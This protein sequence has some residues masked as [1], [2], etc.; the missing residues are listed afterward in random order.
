[1]TPL[2]KQVQKM[3]SLRKNNEIC[4]YHDYYIN[5]AGFGI[6]PVYRGVYHQRGHGLGSFLRGLWRMTFPLIKSGA[7]T[8]GD[9]IL[10]SGSEFLTDVVT[11]KPIKESLR[12]RLNETTKNL[13]KKVAEKMKSMAGSGCCIKSRKRKRKQQSRKSSTHSRFSSKK[14]KRDI[15]D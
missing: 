3:S 14:V 7:K 10:K 11:N 13:G 1:M 8:V 6:G 12:T 9:E 5:Q 4:P 2:S 15:F